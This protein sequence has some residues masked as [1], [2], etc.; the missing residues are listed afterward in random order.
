VPAP[1][2]QPPASAAPNPPPP[3]AVPTT[4]SGQA[5]TA[6]SA[7]VL[8]DRVAAIV[9]RAMAADTE[10]GKSLSKAG[11]VTISRADLDEIR[12]TI[13]QVKTMLQVAAP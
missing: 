2:T 10:S 8:L 12:A 1:T 5:R 6:E 4:N 3:P 7:N 11:K 9:D 13:S